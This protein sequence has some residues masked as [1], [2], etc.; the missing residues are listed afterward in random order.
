MSPMPA[1]SQRPLVNQLLALKPLTINGIRFTSIDD[2]LLSNRLSI[3]DL[4]AALGE[5]DI[6]IGR[7][8]LFRWRK[9]VQ[10]STPG[11]DK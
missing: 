4:A 9:E 5:R 6:S 8:T 10:I 7:E 3:D 11:A 1:Q 2:A